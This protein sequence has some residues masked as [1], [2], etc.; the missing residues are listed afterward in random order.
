M[1]TSQSVSAQVSVALG[2]EVDYD[3]VLRLASEGNRAAASVVTATGRALGRLIA[4]IANI[5]MLDTIVLSGEGIA[6]WALASEEVIAAARADRDPDAT[7]LTIVVDDSGVSSW[8]R[9][10][11]A[12]AIQRSLGRLAAAASE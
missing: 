4:V 12:V 11:A 6:L 2:R 1:L 8:A 10:A 3:E 9:G 7:P 5:G